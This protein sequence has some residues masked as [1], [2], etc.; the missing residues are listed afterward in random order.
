M[1]S[2]RIETLQ[3]P[4]CPG[5]TLY[6]IQPGDTLY[7]LAQ[8]FGTSV[9][10]IL[11]A[12]PGLN[13]RNLQVGQQI[14]I[15]VPEPVTCP[16][17][18]SPYIIKRGDTL[19]AIA[20]R[21]GINLQDLITANP[22]IDPRNLQIGQRICV[23]TPPTPVPELQFPCCTLLN[24][25]Q[26][27]LP[28]PARGSVLVQRFGNQYSLTFAATGLPNLSTLG[29]YDIYIGSIR[30]TPRRTQQA[31]IVF[32]AALGSSALIG[33]PVTWSGTRIIPERPQQEDVVLI[34]AVKLELDIKGPIVLCNTLDACK[35]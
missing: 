4:L 8:Q 35:R 2:K 3:V 29:D 11:N 21:L 9:N 30:M 14:C 18:T 20:Q 7:F 33:Q 22:G 16:P 25:V 15:P 17:G 6:T 19:S 13:P 1:N 24:P 32:S 5:G 28:A 34:R 23:P 10:S 12:N 27:G 26:N 31:P